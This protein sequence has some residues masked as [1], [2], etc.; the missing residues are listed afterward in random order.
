MEE[1]FALT[2]LLLENKVMFYYALHGIALK[3]K[4]LVWY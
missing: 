2:H 3:K 1:S 4:K